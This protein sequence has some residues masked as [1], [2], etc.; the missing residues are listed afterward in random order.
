MTSTPT[1]L[2]PEPTPGA[3][4]TTVR[5]VLTDPRH[6]WT[7]RRMRLQGWRGRDVTQ[8]IAAGWLVSVAPAACAIGSLAGAV[9]QSPLLLL[10]LAATAL[11]GA[12]GPHHP[13]EVVS[14]EIAR[15]RGRT[16]TPPNRAGRRTGCTIG[17]IVLTSAAAAMLWGAPTLGAVLA[18]GLGVVAA[19]VAATNICIPSMVLTVLRG[20]EACTTADPTTRRRIRTG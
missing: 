13:F 14:N 19:F 17:T 2:Q 20:A 3:P 6:D 18:G 12:V 8:A 11:V 7:S 1:H 4:P 5:A 15:R 9:L 16:P 10:A